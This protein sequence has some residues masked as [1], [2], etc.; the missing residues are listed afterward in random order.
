MHRLDNAH[1]DRMMDHQSRQQIA[2]D[3]NNLVGMTL[4]ELYSRLG[5]IRSRYEDALRRL[6]RTE[7]AAEISDVGFADRVFGIV[8]LRL[9]I[10][11]VKTQLILIYG[12]INSTV[13]CLPS[14]RPASVRD[15]P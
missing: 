1:A 13:A 7:T 3:Q 8:F 4:R 11:A 6:V 9:N 14:A 12:P 2:I 5:E 10:D 15:P